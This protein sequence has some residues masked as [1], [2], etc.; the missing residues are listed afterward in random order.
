MAEN[1]MSVEIMNIKNIFKYIIISPKKQHEHFS[2]RKYFTLYSVGFFSLLTV[3]LGIVFISHQKNLLV[4]YA[5]S[6]AGEFAQQLSFHLNNEG[7]VSALKEN[8]KTKFTINSPGFEKLD[9]MIN[10]YLNEFSDIVEIKIFD[11]NSRIVYSKNID[12]VGMVE[13]LD[14]LKM[15]LSGQIASKLTKSERTRSGSIEVGKAYKVDLLEI[16]IP[17]YGERGEGHGG[18]EIV[19]AFEV[20]KDVSVV[21][22]EAKKGGYT[23]FALFTL[24]MFILFLI[25]Q[26]IIRKADGIIKSKNEEINKYNRELEEAQNKISESIDEVIEHESFH[27][28]YSNN[29]LLK[30]WEVKKCNKPDCPSY[31][32]EELRCWQV[33]GTFCGGEVQGV[34]ASKYGDCRKCEVFN[35]AI[36]NRINTI[37]ESF[38]NM[39]TLL[40]NKHMQLQELNKKLEVLIDIDHLTEIG[41]RRSFQKRIENIHLLSLRYNHPYSIIICDIDNFKLYNDTYGHQQGDYVLV[42]VANTMKSSIRRTDEIFRWGGEEFIMILPEQNMSD[43]LK[44]AEYLRSTVHALSI[45][46]QQSDLKV[47]TVSCGV[48]SFYP[49]KAR[50]V[51]W[52]YVVK[53]ADDALYKAKIGKKNC[54]YSAASAYK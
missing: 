36:N 12:D 27:V 3:L 21:F 33:A 4:D 30:C 2:I 13:T 1:G 46:H 7:L 6:T 9:I 18:R 32:S 54:V 31:E 48:A 25:L 8:T 15:A 53:E 38:N 19:G 44:V 50:N 39:M 43:A 47:V 40:Q 22:K 23:I 34:F 10:A 29:Y 17:I 11:S 20:Y 52:E 28:R 5:V 26:M 42:S 24:L 16:Y 14:G 41:N 35:H 45:K 49:W 37:G 51:G